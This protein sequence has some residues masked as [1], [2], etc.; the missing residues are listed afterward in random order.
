MEMPLEIHAFVLFMPLHYNS[1]DLYLVNVLFIA[2][3][4]QG[5]LGGGSLSMT[6][7]PPFFISAG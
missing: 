6:F 1:I 4:L 5:H 2:N 3:I 7:C